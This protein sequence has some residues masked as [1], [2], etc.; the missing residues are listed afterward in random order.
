MKSVISIIVAGSILFTL[1]AFSQTASNANG[2]MEILM[3]KIKADK[4]LLVAT[5]MDLTDA[6]GK[7]FWPLYDAYQSELLKI[8]EQLGKI[9]EN[10]A[11]AYNQGTG[12]IS[13][14]MARML[15]NEVI[16]I[17]EHEVKLKRIFL[18]KI[19]A[20]LSS[21]KTARYIQIEGKIR[22]A[23]KYELAQEVP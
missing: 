18:K 20:V 4:K 12:G 21:A 8:D 7:A 10:Y 16:S 13:N 15:I 11:A 2:N 14:D 17:E 22:A 3:Q 19:G 9:I 1:P 5:N 6:E 23:L